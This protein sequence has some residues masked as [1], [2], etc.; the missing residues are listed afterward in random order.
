VLQIL[1]RLFDFIDWRNNHPGEHTPPDFLNASFDAQNDKI[2]EIIVFVHGIRR[3]DGF[4]TNEIVTW[5]SLDEPLKQKIAETLTKGVEEASKRA[6]KAADRAYHD[7]RAAQT[8]R[9]IANVGAGRAQ[10]AAAEVD[11]LRSPAMAQVERLIQA[12]EALKSAISATETSLLNLDEDWNAS[13]AAALKWA[14]TSAVWAE[15]MPDQIPSN[16]LAWMGV[17]GDHWSARWWANKADNAFGRLTD[18]YLGAWPDPPLTNLEG[19]PIETGSIYYDTDDGQPYVWDGNSWVPFWAPNRAVTSTLWYLASEGQ[20]VFPLTTA[21]QN[22]NSYTI[23]QDHPEGLNVFVN[24]IRLVPGYA[25][26][27]E[28]DYV[29]DVPSSTVTM[30]RPLRAGDLVAVDFLLSPEKLAPGAVTNWSVNYAPALDGSTVS[31]DLVPK[32]SGPPVNVVRPEE[33]LVS[34]DG[35]IQEPGNSYTAIA[36]QITFAQA[37]AADSRLFIVWYQSAAG[38]GP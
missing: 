24:G 3:S 16:I 21:D 25:S 32:G 7:A 15:W 34:L 5:D 12:A 2:N 4:I 36:D 18:L 9:D 6:E 8:A 35:V 28:V 27:I 1:H 17:T 29:V 38:G 26:S 30:A 23:D 10:I 37:P 33:L 14:E 31:F 13:S 19:G 20:T 11:N 22:G